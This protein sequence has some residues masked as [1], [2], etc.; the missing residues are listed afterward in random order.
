MDSIK[1]AELIQAYELLSGIAGR[2]STPVQAGVLMLDARDL[3]QQE[4]ANEANKREDTV[5]ET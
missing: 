1:V 2:T 4:I 5:A 3:I